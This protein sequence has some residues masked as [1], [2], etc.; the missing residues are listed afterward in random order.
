[1]QRQ[2]D[3][4]TNLPAFDRWETSQRG[5][6]HSEVIIAKQRHGPLD[7]LSFSLMACLL[8]LE[9]DTAYG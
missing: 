7:L 5:S 3:H 4:L 2:D 1:M 9:S 8:D 6:H